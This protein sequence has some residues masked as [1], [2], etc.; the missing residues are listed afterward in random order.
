MA[1]EVEQK[2]GI[3]GLNVKLGLGKVTKKKSP[4]PP[5][6]LGYGNMPQLPE[7]AMKNMRE[8]QSNPGDGNP[9]TEKV[10][11]R[12]ARSYPGGSKKEIY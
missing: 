2:E 5:T 6:M 4:K 1:D 8:E 7:I 10:K 11:N 9:L 12:M 3:L